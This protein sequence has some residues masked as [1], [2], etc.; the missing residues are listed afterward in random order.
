MP[1]VDF[2]LP[3][4][5]WENRCTWRAGGQVGGCRGWLLGGLWVRLCAAWVQLWVG[6]LVSGRMCHL[7]GGAAGKGVPH[8]AQV[9]LQADEAAPK[10]TRYLVRGAAEGRPPLVTP[11]PA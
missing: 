11:I 9:Q 5:C 10:Q 6:G 2:P 4:P 7:V 1:R 8:A 3:S